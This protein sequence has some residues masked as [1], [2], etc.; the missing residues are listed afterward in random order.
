AQHPLV[1][2]LSSAWDSLTAESDEGI[3]VR[4]L[5]RLDPSFSV[6]DWKRDIQEL[7]LPEYMSAFLRGDVKLL[8]QWTGEA[9]YNKLA[10]EAKQRKADGMVLVR[11]LFF[12]LSFARVRCV[13]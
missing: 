6:E 13:V 5:R 8:K 3:G 11:N 1:Y 2:K 4:E 7:F 12:I 10:S 9:C